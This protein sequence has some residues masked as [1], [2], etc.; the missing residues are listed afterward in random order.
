VL[1]THFPLWL[2][3]FRYHEAA[4]LLERRPDTVF[5]SMVRTGESWP[6]P[7]YP[8]SDFA[9]LSEELGVTDVYFVFLNFAVSVLGL[10]DH[11]GTATCGGIPPDM[12]V[13]PVLAERGIR[14]HMTMYP[15][16]GLD[17]D[18]DPELMRAVADRC[19]TVFTN[20]AEAVAAVPQAIR[21]AGPMAT[22]LYAFRPRERRTPFRFVFA[23]DHRPRKGLD[24]AL[25]AL[26]QLD[27]RFH[28]HVVGPH[29]PFVRHV[30]PERLTY[31][32][33]LQ[34][35][36]LRGVYW[37]CDAFVSPVRPEGPDGQP[38]EVGL[39]D[40]FPTTTACEA[41]ASG[42]ALVSSN[43]RGEHWIVEPD[44][45]FLEFGVHDADALADCL[46]RLEADRDLRDALAERGAARIRE[47]MDVR[48]VVDAKLR[49]MDLVAATG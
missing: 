21:I 13:A 49:A 31:H 12:G 47:V 30:P 37:A 10:R 32:G 41:L 25:A 27:E 24:T 34:P 2:S 42:C 17:T 14:V 19:T 9:R 46:R 8:L 48:R 6:R 38:G 43:P 3:G 28:L 39:V 16:G 40:G 20:T 15:G 23:A 26:A 35:A 36:D 22:E 4:E 5:F 18:T 29:E 1:D 11:P 7:V 45:H 44:E 33:V